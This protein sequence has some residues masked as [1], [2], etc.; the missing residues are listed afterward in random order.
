MNSIS[1]LEIEDLGAK[2]NAVFAA[3]KLERQQLASWPGSSNGKIAFL[4]N[5]AVLVRLLF[6]DLGRA[7][8]VIASSNRP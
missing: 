5:P 8:I 3:R 1:V 2:I 6:Q 7:Q 4:K